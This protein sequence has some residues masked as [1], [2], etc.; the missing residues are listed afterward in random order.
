MPAKF[1]VKHDGAIIIAGSAPTF[2]KSVSFEI[3]NTGDAPLKIEHVTQASGNV[4]IG[5]V[6]ASPATIA[7][8]AEHP[9]EVSHK[10]PMDGTAIIAFTT[11]IGL[12]NV[13]VVVKG[14]PG[15]DGGSLPLPD[16]GIED[17]SGGGCFDGDTLVLLADGSA[18][19]I[20]ELVV[21]DRLHTIGEL[22]HL[23][24]R[25]VV[26]PA[27]VEGVLRHGREQAVIAIGDI[28]TTA[29]HRWAV[30][31]TREPR[32]VASEDL[33]AGKHELLVCDGGAPAWHAVPARA[34]AAP[35]AIVWNLE[36]TARTYCVAARAGGPFF[37]VHNA[38]K[39][40]PDWN[41][42][43]KPPKP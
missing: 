9:V 20:R 8:G 22:D 3:K 40:E 23:T 13:A 6:A 18:R 42:P 19:A 37:V 5:I 26:A 15:I 33:D 2:M 11:N 31:D 43:T 25:P 16:P 14:G 10:G 32:F 21:G 17:D 24:A 12:H 30:R 38:K 34:D 4:E 27:I 36:T 1:T 7:A 41:D 28:V 29:D 35:R 39:I